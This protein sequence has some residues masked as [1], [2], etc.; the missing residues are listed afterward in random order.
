MA[1]AIEGIYH[2]YC[3]RWIKVIRWKEWGHRIVERAKF[4]GLFVATPAFFIY[5]FGYGD[6][7]LAI[8]LLFHRPKNEEELMQMKRS[9]WNF[10][11]QRNW[12]YGQYQGDMP[13]VYDMSERR[14]KYP[15]YYKGRYDGF[16][17]DRRPFVSEKHVVKS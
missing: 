6:N 2:K 7:P 10:Y 14:L 9:T 8:R 11:A 4:N 13:P 17:K 5:T 16:K 1:E 12:E 3:P 15:E